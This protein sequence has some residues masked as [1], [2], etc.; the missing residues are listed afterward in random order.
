MARDQ[1]RGF[2][3]KFLFLIVLAGVVLVGLAIFR[4]GASPEIALDSDLPGIGKRTTLRVRVAEPQRG[5]GVVRAELQ[6]GERV[7]ALAER[8]YEPL[9]FWQF[10]GERQ[11]EDEWTFEVG[12]AS[13][14]WLKEGP[15]TVRVVA[16]RAGTWLRSP[17]PVVAE[18]TL[19]V[20]LRPPGLQVLSTATYVGQGG[21]EAVVY[22]VGE[23]AVR[24]GVQAGDWWFPGHPLPG[25][26]ER[27]RF[28]LFAAPYDLDDPGA[29]RLVAADDVGNEARASFVEE[30][31]PAPVKRDT[32]V[33]TESFLARVVPAILE[34]TPDLRDRGSLLDN[35]L[36][37][38]REL[39]RAN[40]AELVE[41]AK[42]STPQ[43]L[44]NRTFL[45]MRNAQEMSAFADRR[46]YTYD[47]R[48]VDQQD[49]LGFDLASVRNA[50]IEA[51]NSGRVLLAR[52]FGIYGN[53]VVL[54]HGYG[55]MSLYGHLSS[56]GVEEGQTV[57]RGQVVG[58]S[59]E[60]GLAGGDHLHF[61]MLLAG[62]PVTPREWWDGHWI[63]DRLVRKLGAALPFVE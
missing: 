25:G 31:F 54:D 42:Q 47:G 58:R 8:T 13:Q 36:E 19:G 38:N 7:V 46:T 48:A 41:L 1:S 39:R 6:Q 28:A 51:A 3:G 11:R 12:S 18:K 4:V 33:L 45:P 16:S 57:E 5:L 40:N 44:W 23:T 10:W 17:D 43:F 29:I 30:F 37:I 59:G 49:H 27:Q 52:Y 26:G 2:F 35:Y 14:A 56:F 9:R 62:F 55:L 63:Q 60:T 21:C 53:T 22:R 34:R 32:I 50:P 24:D 15:A 20:R 61:T